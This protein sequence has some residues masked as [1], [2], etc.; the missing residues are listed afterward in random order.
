MCWLWVDRTKIYGSTHGSTLRLFYEL[1]FC[2]MSY[3]GKVYELYQISVAGHF[4]MSEFM[5]CE[6]LPVRMARWLASF[7]LAPGLQIAHWSPTADLVKMFMSILWVG[8]NSRARF[9]LGG[10]R[11]LSTTRT[12]LCCQT[13]A[14]KHSSRDAICDYELELATHANSSALWGWFY[15]LFNILRSVLWVFYES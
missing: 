10:F 4:F 11:S 13:A 7:L 9:P 12:E 15:E 14:T 5:S 1:D 8:S 6:Q 2:F 3:P